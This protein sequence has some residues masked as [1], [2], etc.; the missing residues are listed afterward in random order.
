MTYPML[1]KGFDAV[2]S[3]YLFMMNTGSSIGSY[4]RMY[5]S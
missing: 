3:L 5:M 2:L 4:I 1:M